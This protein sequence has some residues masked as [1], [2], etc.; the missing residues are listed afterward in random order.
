MK[1]VTRLAAGAVLGTILLSATACGNDKDILQST[2]EDLTTVMT[3]A[4][5][6]VPLE[7]YRYVALNYKNDYESEKSSDIWLGEAGT[8]LMQ[9]LNADVEE[10]IVTLYAT[11]AMCEEYGIRADDA[12]IT[13]SLEITMDAVYEE[14]EYDYK[15]YADAIAQHNMNDSVYRFV[16]RNELLA[17]ELLNAMIERGEIPNDDA[18]VQAV[19]DSDE[20]IRVKQILISTEEDMLFS[21]GDKMSEEECLAAAEDLLAQAKGGADFDELVQKKGQDLF[22]FNNDDGYYFARGYL[23]QAF[24]DAAFALDIGEISDVVRTSAGYSIIKRYEKDPAYIDKHFDDLRGDY[25]GGLYNLAVDAFAEGLTVTPTDALA[26]YSI[27]NL[28][29]VKD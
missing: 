28:T 15:A 17:D 19:F 2:K 18:S 16:L 9:E 20:F 12:Y 3:V 7:M 6:D 25:I 5:H 4:G 8:A 22:M 13:D 10:T 1:T 11:L 26:D 21:S 23:D 27:F 14:Y 29:P 24:E